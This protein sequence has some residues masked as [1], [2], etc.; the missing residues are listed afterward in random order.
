[1]RNGTNMGRPKNLWWVSLKEVS[2][3]GEPTR[4]L[5]VADAKGPR[6]ENKFRIKTIYW[7]APPL[8][9]R[10]LG[11]FSRL[12]VASESLGIQKF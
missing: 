5:I 8:M 12:A 2:A 7:P 9:Q 10:V 3:E 4:E 1:M 11:R 6:W